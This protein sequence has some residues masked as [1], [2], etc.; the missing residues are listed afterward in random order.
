MALNVHFF[1]FFADN[2]LADETDRPARL[3]QS[4]VQSCAPLAVDTLVPLMTIR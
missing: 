4:A 2:R 1:V 3:V